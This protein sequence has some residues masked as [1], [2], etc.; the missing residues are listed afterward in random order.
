MYPNQDFKKKHN[1]IVLVII[2]QQIKL[3]YTKKSIV[4]LF[5]S[6]YPTADKFFLYEVLI[7]TL[8]INSCFIFSAWPCLYLFFTSSGSFQKH[9]LVRIRQFSPFAMILSV[10]S[11]FLGKQ[12][13]QIRS[14]LF[15]GFKSWMR[16]RLI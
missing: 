13:W 15:F 14:I 6:Q 12:T 1:V 4:L 3:F 5:F 11:T 9:S 10:P 2:Y 16:G 8:E 7:K